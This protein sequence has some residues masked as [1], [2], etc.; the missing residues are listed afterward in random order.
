MCL[1]CK[2]CVNWKRHLINHNSCANSRI[3][4]VFQEAMVKIVCDHVYGTHY[5]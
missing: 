4:Y 5:M 3:K 1:S 2:S